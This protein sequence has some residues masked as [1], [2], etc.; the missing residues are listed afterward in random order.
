MFLLVINS[1]SIG[2]EIKCYPGLDCP[3]DLKPKINNTH[4]SVPSANHELNYWLD[5]K[6]CNQLVCYKKF[7]GRYP[8]GKYSSLARKKIELL[9]TTKPLNN[10]ST[11]KL[12]RLLKKASNG[13][14]TIDEIE[15]IIDHNPGYSI[16][17]TKDIERAKQL[18]K[19]KL[20]TLKFSK[21][22]VGIS[23]LPLA[24]KIRN[25]IIY[26]LLYNID[27]S[28]ELHPVVL[29]DKSIKYK[30]IKHAFDSLSINEI[31]YFIFNL[32][33]HKSPVNKNTNL[34]KKY[35]KFVKIKLLK[36]MSSEGYSKDPMKHYYGLTDM[37]KEIRR[38][39]MPDILNKKLL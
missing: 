16:N 29:Y 22:S 9:E 34:E 18:Q 21:K 12:K 30:N 8:H 32:N 3:D 17:L 27:Y 25:L 28:K 31:K 5:T 1:T 23:Y 14:F 15:L 37:G 33:F 2:R 10:H 19:Y 4:R 11:L 24:E 7:L 6:K 26:E 39:Q 20:V 35:K 13:E 36:R 38:V